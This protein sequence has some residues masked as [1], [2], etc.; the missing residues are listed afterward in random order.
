MTLLKVLYII[1]IDLVLGIYLL[2]GICVL[3]DLSVQ[4]QTITL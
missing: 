3:K 1:D 4:F 2:L